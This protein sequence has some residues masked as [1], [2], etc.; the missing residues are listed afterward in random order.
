VSDRVKGYIERERIIESMREREGERERE[1]EK[2]KRE[3]E[4]GVRERDIWGE[5][6]WE[7]EIEVKSER[8]RER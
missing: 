5:K 4:K 7:R 3:R 6:W 1:R 2:K 8:D